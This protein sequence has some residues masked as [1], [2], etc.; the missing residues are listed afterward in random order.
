MSHRSTPTWVD[1]LAPD[2]GAALI[3]DGYLLL[4]GAVPAAWRDALR[5]AFDAG[6]GTGDQWS[7]PRGNGWRHA[8]V[9]LDLTVQRTCRLPLLLAAA[10]QMLAGPFFIAQV[11]GREPLPG[12]GHQPLHRDGAGTKAVAALVF[13]DAYGP[14]NGATRV[15]PRHLDRGGPDEASAGIM[16]GE[17]GDILVF[18]ADL[19]HGATLN[20][21]GARR[22]SLLLSFMHE[23]Y[24]A[25][26]DACRAVRN[27]RMDTSELF[28]PLGT[29]RAG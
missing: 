14:D 22:R 16:A 8:L 21:S 4:R 28:V 25:S 17:A 18:D 1:P 7:A 20:R 27:V 24:R 5:A 23:R 6:V 12:G 15:V 13:L 9:D 3:R 11:E 2:Q 29:V 19:P 10:A 26:Q